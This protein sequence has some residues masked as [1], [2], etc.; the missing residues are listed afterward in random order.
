[1]SLFDIKEH[2]AEAEES[3]RSYV[4]SSLQYYR[5]K[6][7]KSMMQGITVTA[8][9][10]L[11]GTMAVMALLLLSIAASF[12]IGDLLDSNA[13]GF[14]VVGGFYILI[15]L[16]IYFFRRRLESPLLRKFSEFYFD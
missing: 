14:L 12:W 13:K 3:A 15:G 6:S 4:D 7:F 5:L 16:F 1:M 10:L 2:I 9:V 11:I 8:K